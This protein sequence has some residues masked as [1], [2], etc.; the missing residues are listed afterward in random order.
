MGGSDETAR[1]QT[2]MELF[3][4]GGMNETGLLISPPWQHIPNDVMSQQQRLLP[5]L[6]P[7]LD[8]PSNWRFPPSEIKRMA[9]KCYCYFPG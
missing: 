7:G 1:N 4:F 3:Y 9:Q 2:E 5:Y 8:T 6:L